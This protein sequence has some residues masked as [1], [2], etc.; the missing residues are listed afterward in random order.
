MEWVFRYYRRPLKQAKDTLPPRDD[1]VECYAHT[2]TKDLEK[3]IKLQVCTIDLQYKVKQVVKD[4]WDV[5]CEEG[6]R[7]TIWGFHSMLTHATPQLSAT[8]HPGIRP[9]E[10]EVVKNLWERLDENGV[11]EYENMPW[12]KYQWILCVSYQT[13]N[14]IT[15]PFDFPIPCS[16]DEV[17]EIDTEAKYFIAVVM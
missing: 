14:Q 6:F 4:Y 13:L 15:C 9:H 7:R 3:N 16:D 8:N 11:A 12:Y 5:F 1:V 10:Y 17:Q 2:N